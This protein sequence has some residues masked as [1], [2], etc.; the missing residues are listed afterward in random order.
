MRDSKV[1]LLSHCRHKAIYVWQECDRKEMLL[2]HV[3]NWHSGDVTVWQ[4][5]REKTIFLF[6]HTAKSYVLVMTNSTLVAMAQQAKANRQV[7]INK[8]KIFKKGQKNVRHF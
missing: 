7:C 8:K 2:S 4:E 6:D 1:I 3:T 5:N